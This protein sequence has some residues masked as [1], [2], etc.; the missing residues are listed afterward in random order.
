V[1]M[2]VSANEVTGYDHNDGSD[3]NYMEARL[4]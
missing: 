1:M 4:D 3:E 2:Y